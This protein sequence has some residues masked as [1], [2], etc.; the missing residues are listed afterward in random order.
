MKLFML[1]YQ[2]A[3]YITGKRIVI[4][5]EGDDNGT[6]NLVAKNQITLKKLIQAHTMTPCQ[7]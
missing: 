1:R 4:V 3:A 5:F 7:L 2:Q 6:C